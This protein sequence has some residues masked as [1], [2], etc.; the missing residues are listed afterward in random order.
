MLQRDP[1]APKQWL[2]VATWGRRL[3]PQER[4]EPVPL[5]EAKAVQEGFHK[6]G[7]LAITAPALTLRVSFELH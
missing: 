4:Q 5:L 1:K 7:S 6:L 2:P 3:T